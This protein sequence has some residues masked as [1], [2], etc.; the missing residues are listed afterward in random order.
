MPPSLEKPR[1]H[2]RLLVRSRVALASLV[3]LS[4]AA[5]LCGLPPAAA[6]DYPAR[7]IRVITVTSAG[8]TSDIFMR[9]WRTRCTR[10][11]ASRS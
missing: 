9:R 2:G 11:S 3:V 4:L 6:Q 1:G 5:L 7:P 8:G 10:V